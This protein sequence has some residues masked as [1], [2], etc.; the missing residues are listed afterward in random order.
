[1]STEFNKRM[2]VAAAKLMARGYSIDEIN[3][4]SWYDVIGRTEG[5]APQPGRNC[6]TGVFDGS[7]DDD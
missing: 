3:A 1:M 6:Y 2:D 7:G 4:M 5:D